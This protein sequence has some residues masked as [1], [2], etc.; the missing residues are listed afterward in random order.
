MSLHI[1]VSFPRVFEPKSIKKSI[2]VFFVSLPGIIS[3]NLKYLGGLKKCVP[4]NNSLKFFDLPS[5]ICLIGIPDVL[6]DI[7]VLFDLCFSIKS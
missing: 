5:D 6:V 3:N 7:I 2:T 1:T 4:K